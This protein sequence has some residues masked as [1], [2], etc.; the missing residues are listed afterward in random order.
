VAHDPQ[1][2]AAWR[3]KQARP[4]AVVASPQTALALVDQ[5]RAVFAASGCAACHTIR[6]TEANGLAGP[7]LTHVGSRQTLGA[8]ILPNNQGTMA[9]WIADSQGV[10]PGNRMPSYPV[11]TGQDLRAVSAYLDS[12]K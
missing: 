1:A 7:D 2:Y 12:L 8:G 6:G 5:G 11:L 4:A 10:K 9:G 3:E